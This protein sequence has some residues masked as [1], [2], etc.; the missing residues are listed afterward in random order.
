MQA[1]YESTIELGPQSLLQAGTLAGEW[2]LDARRSSIRLKAWHLWRLAPVSGVFRELS[3]SATVSPDGRVKGTVT[4]AASSIDTNNP[5]RDKHLRSKAFLDSDTY[6][7]II[8]TVDQIHPSGHGVAVS[9]TATVRDCTRP[10]SFEATVSVQD[11]GAIWLD[12]EVPINRVDFGLTWNVLGI[13]STNITLTIH[14]VFTRRGN[15]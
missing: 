2:T 10:L 3:G 6:P 7:D 11:D 9:G 5:R 4:V 13:P 12:A 1:A 15:R 14:A 8:Y